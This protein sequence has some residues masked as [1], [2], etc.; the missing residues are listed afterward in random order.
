MT[1]SGIISQTEYVPAHEIATA[2]NWKHSSPIAVDEINR[3]AKNLL[4]NVSFNLL[5]I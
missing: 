3:I 2:I 1:A 4:L 5:K